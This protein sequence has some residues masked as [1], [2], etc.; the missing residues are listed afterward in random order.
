MK[1]KHHFRKYWRW[2]ICTV[3][4]EYT[5]NGQRADERSLVETKM[6]AWSLLNVARNNFL[7]VRYKLEVAHEERREKGREGSSWK[8]IYYRCGHLFRW[9][10][11]N[12]IECIEWAV[13]FNLHLHYC[14]AYIMAYLNWCRRMHITLLSLWNVTVMRYV[15]KG[16][17]SRM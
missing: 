7:I 2:V 16:W 15:Q 3:T 9:P 1:V 14:I 12:R 11:W 6:V 8:F 5:I 13:I 4:G 17:C 10:L